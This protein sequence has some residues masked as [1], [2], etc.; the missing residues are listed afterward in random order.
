MV[1]GTNSIYETGEEE[2]D[3]RDPR[4]WIPEGQRFAIVVAREGQ[5]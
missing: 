4:D 5:S 1:S 2:E 3:L